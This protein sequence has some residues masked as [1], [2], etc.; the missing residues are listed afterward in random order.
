MLG[1]CGGGGGSDEVSSYKAVLHK[2][3]R[4]LA[5][6][7]SGAHVILVGGSTR[8]GTERERERLSG[9]CRMQHVR[10]R[11][12]LVGVVGVLCSRF[13]YCSSFA[14]ACILYFFV[15]TSYPVCLGIYTITP[16]VIAQSGDGASSLG[17]H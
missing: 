16:L 14:R 4:E 9:G 5:I 3:C 17:G 13:V 7:G 8:A 6:G 15:P 2:A 11:G 10:W 1:E 12:P